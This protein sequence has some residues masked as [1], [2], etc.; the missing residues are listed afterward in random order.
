MTSTGEGNTELRVA[1]IE[2]GWY[3]QEAAAEGISRAGQVALRD[4]HFTVSPRTYRRW[5][6]TRP[7]WPRGDYATALRA[8]FGRAPEQ[9]G[10]TPPPGHPARQQHIPEPPVDRRMF[11][12]T[13]SAAALSSLAPDDLTPRHIDPALVDYFYR[14][15]DGHYAADMML[16]PR[17]L[18]PTVTEQY[19]LISSLARRANGDTRDGLVHVGA[20]YAV[21]AG[22]L[23]Q[24][25]AL[26]ADAAYWH[27]IAQTDALISG[28]PDLVAYTISHMAHL[29]A[30]LGDGRA[31][32]ALCERALADE[33]RLSDRIRANLMYQQAHG[34]ALL[35][36]RRAVDR[37]LDQASRATERVDPAI[38]WGTAARRNAHYT[39]VQ[40][41]T[42]YGRMGL[43]R[44][45]LTLW[46][47]I[48]ATMP[49]TARRD[50]GVYLARQ[51]SAHASTGEPERAVELAAESARI[52]HDTASG[53]H[54]A[55]L[56]RLR[57]AMIPWRD[58][59]LGH[60]LDAA[61]TT[62]A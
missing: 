58:D 31:V 52:A 4:P 32:V 7:G 57:E 55:E 24:D 13:G 61:L 22:W 41:A 3:S 6:S 37:L 50:T 44:E 10:F 53:R 40:R 54:R 23:H 30:D 25:A 8:A 17:E 19:R 60:Q 62:A 15:L 11:L 39:A 43:H 42:C 36:D 35:G 5:E 29:R 33:R 2:R 34:A 28:D 27:G 20:T 12:A 56:D 45:A 9:L 21:L 14:Q 38:P 16:G 51:A 59:R 18:I 1:R 46:D 26:W 49:P 48:T 47:H